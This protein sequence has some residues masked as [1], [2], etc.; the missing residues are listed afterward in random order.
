MIVE[1]VIRWGVPFLCGGI[2]GG[3]IFTYKWIRA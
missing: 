1:L 2:L 3:L